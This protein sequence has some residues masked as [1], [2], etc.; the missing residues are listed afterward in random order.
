MYSL[1]LV[2]YDKAG[3]YKSGR[4]LFLF[5]NLSTVDIQ[6]N[7]PTYC[8]TG[9]KDTSYTWVTKDTSRVKIDWKSRFIN[10][11]HNA[12]KWLNPVQ[13]FAKGEGVVTYEDLYGSR[14]H[15]GIKN[16]GGMFKY[17]KIPFLVTKH[18]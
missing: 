12:G 2:A 8:S 15:V 10:I 3:N 7:K 9:S 17:F 18:P 11:R 1:H 5:D 13:T 16:V 6:G 14:T 4:T